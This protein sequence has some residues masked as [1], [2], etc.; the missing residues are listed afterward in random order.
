MHAIKIDTHSRNATK[1]QLNKEQAVK[2]HKEV[3]FFF[4]FL[5]AILKPDFD[6]FG[7]D[8]GQNGT[9]AY[10]LLP[11]QRTGLRALGVDPFERLDL[12][13]GV[14]DVFPGVEVPV[15]AVAA[16]AAT[17]IPVM[18]HGHRHFSKATTTNFY[19]PLTGE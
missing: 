2:N 15:E 9:V 17:A 6:L 18:R 3:L 14:P 19:N 5:P 4:P 16:A 10:Q 11:A 8:V 7:L 1:I 12:L 13:G